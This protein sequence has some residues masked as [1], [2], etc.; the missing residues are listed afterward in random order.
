MDKLTP[1]AENNSRRV[2]PTTTPIIPRPRNLRPSLLTHQTTLYP[3]QQ[4]TP[5]LKVG[6][7]PALSIPQVV[8][9]TTEIVHDIHQVVRTTAQVTQLLQVMRQPVQVMRQLVQVMRQIV[10]VMRQTVQAMRQLVQVMRQIVPVMRQIVQVMRQIVQ[11]MRQI[12]QVM[13]Q[14][15]QA[16]QILRLIPRPWTTL[17]LAEPARLAPLRAAGPKMTTL[18]P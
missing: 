15:V 17:M 11:A 10:P 13:R 1:G 14:L 16:L 5:P 6:E 8:Q 7:R 9:A 12:V 2:R 18:Q 4:D 3:F